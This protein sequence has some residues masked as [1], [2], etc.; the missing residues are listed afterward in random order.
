M[1]KVSYTNAKGLFQETG[2]GFLPS[3]GNSGEIQGYGARRS[4]AFAVSL[5]DFETSYSPAIADR[6]VL[7][8]LGTLDVTTS[9]GL[10]PTR[11]LVERV[12]VNVTTA[13][14]LSTDASI[15][16]I[17]NRIKPCMT[18]HADAWF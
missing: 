8:Q 3:G 11:I 7:I 6:D 1:P 18:G 14:G 13:S 17:F 15:S 10:T 2:T 9:N 5:A 16:G 12:I 4:Q